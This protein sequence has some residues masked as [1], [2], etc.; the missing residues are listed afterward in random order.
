MMNFRISIAG[1]ALAACIIA[2]VPSNAGT[3][4][5]SLAAWTAAVGGSFETTSDT[6][7]GVGNF[8]TGPIPLSGGQSF[9]VAGADDQVLQPLNGWGPWSGVYAGDI[10][11]TTTNA[12]TI[13]FNH[14]GAGIDGLGIDLSPD[15]PIFC[16]GGGTACQDETFT[17]TLSDGTTTQISGVYPPGVTQFVGF[18][19]S[20][21]TSMT[22]AATNAPDFAFGDFRD[23]P[24]PMSMMLLASGLAGLGA[25]RRRKG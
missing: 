19:G 23:V 15:L 3:I 4:Y 11:D 9:S 16:I 17:V 25:I 7:V 2:P 21:I 13:S 22:I 14:G 20:N 12:E 1:A 5:S 24:E 6:G 18:A 8:V 10:I